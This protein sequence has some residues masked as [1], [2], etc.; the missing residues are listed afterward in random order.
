MTDKLNHS[1]DIYYLTKIQYSLTKI[2]ISD[3]E[4]KIFIIFNFM[5]NNPNFKY[6]KITYTQSVYE[7]EN[8]IEYCEIVHIF[9]ATNIIKIPQFILEPINEY[10]FDD[11][12]SFHAPILLRNPIYYN[13]SLLFIERLLILNIISTEDE[14]YKYNIKYQRYMCLYLGDVA[15]INLMGKIPQDVVRYIAMFL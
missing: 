6:K 4:Y 7:L 9:Y 15:S 11:E 1:I 12:Y 2:R 5:L 13:D 3:E 10:K 8:I 14:I